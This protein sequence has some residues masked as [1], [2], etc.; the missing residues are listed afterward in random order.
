[1]SQSKPFHSQKEGKDNR[2]DELFQSNIKSP[3]GQT[4]IPS[5]SC[6]ASEVT[7]VLCEI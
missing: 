3:T 5:A 6:L 1:M 2:K 4:L 7:V